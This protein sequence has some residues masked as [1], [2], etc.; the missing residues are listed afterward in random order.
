MLKV[1]NI[2]DAKHGPQEWLTPLTL[3]LSLH[4]LTLQATSAIFLSIVTTRVSTEL[5][6]DELHMRELKGTVLALPVV[7]TAHGKAVVR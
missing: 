1:S 5:L 2:H 7:E 6:T 4:H 3:E